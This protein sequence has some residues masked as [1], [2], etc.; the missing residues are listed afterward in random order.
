MACQTRR[1]RSRIVRWGGGPGHLVGGTGGSRRQPDATVT[2]A[3]RAPDPAPSPVTTPEATIQLSSPTTPGS[4]KLPLAGSYPA[5][6]ALALLALSPFLVLTTAV[7]LF[8]PLLMRELDATRFELQ[9]TSGLSNAGY[10]FGAVVAADLTLRLA[11][12]HVYLVCEA[13]FVVSSVLA[14]SAQGIAQFMAGVVLQGLFTG[15]LLVVALPPLI[16]AHGIDRL[17]T[18]A[19]VISLGLFGMVTAGPVVG[20]L[21]GSMGGWRLLFT[22]VAVLAATGLTVGAMTFEKNAPPNRRAGF[23]WL[24]IP[25][26]LGATVLPF[27]GVS[28]LSRGSFEHPAFLAPVVVGLLIGVFLVVGQYHKANPLMPVRPISNT[29]PVTGTVNAMVVGAS[30]TTLLEL[31]EIYLLQVSH[32]SPVRTGLLV[33]PQILGVVIAAALFRRT[34]S[35]RFTPYLALSGL[36]SVSVGAAVLLS[37]TAS[38]STTVVPV[39]ALFLGYGAGAGVAPGLFLAGFS[40]SAVQIGPTFALVELLRSEAA[41]LLGP[42]LLHLTMTRDTIDHG[43]HLSVLITLVATVAVGI[44]LVVLFVLGGARPV[45]PDL[46]AWMSGTSTGYHSPALAARLRKR[47]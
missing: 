13:G 26:A 10:A 31:V 27:F 37:V 14:L 5:A 35:T 29:L 21:V 1:A 24:A 16:L 47:H 25:L 34:V 3:E 39:A 18:T 46:E 28:W 7:S 12:R 11:R 8:Q 33:A 43:F 19:S 15:M 42:I 30:F 40:V 32:C 41:F 22:S 17:P 9:L 36:V 6:V 45:A 38:N 44:A 4:G 20:G 23:D 2:G